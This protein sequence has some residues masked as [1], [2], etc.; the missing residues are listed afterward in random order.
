VKQS[1]E[2]VDS[3]DKQKARGMAGRLMRHGLLS[4]NFVLYL[5]IIFFAGLYLFMPYIAGSRNL[6]NI[7]SNMWPLLAL[8]LGQMFV[9]ILGGIDLSQT[10]IMALTSVVGGMLMT[11]QLDPTLF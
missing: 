8:V 1:G 6:A 4:E 5:S 7:S 10:S 2:Q 3:S 9:L 11:T